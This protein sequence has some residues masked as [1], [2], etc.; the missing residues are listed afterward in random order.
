[1]IF[2]AEA[3][4]DKVRLVTWLAERLKEK[5]D[6]LVGA[7]P[8]EVWAVVK[9]AAIQGVV[10][11]INYRGASIEMSCAGEPGW[12]TRKSLRAFFHFPFVQ[13]KCRRV[14]GIVHRKNKRARDV[15]ERMGFRLE[16]VCKHG[17]ENGDA[18]VYGMTRAECR[19]IEQANGQKSSQSPHRSRNYG[20]SGE[21]ERR[22]GSG[23]PAV[24]N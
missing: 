3:W 19:W 4:G 23:E 10:L 24:P 12:L 7:M 9:N 5:P 8:F 15:N 1:L 13:L 6:D 18:M 22:N 2:R 17:F 14:T 16:G 21:D 20:R 11:Y